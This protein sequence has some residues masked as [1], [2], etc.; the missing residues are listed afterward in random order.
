[1]IIVPMVQQEWIV[2][3]VISTDIFPFQTLIFRLYFLNMFC[4]TE[5]QI[6]EDHT[7]SCDFVKSVSECES[8]AYELGLSD[9][10]ATVMPSS[11]GWKTSSPPFCHIHDNMLYF[12]P[13]N[14][15]P[16]DV[17]KKCI[18]KQN[19]FCTKLP[20]QEGQGDCDND[21]ECEGTLVCGDMNCMN[22]TIADCC[23]QPC[24]KD[25]DC[26]S[27]ECDLEHNKCRLNFESIDWSKCSRD[28]PCGNGEGDCDNHV[29]CKG[30]LNCGNDN[31]ASGPIGI[32]C[33]TDNGN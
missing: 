6:I 10:S 8:A 27:G 31:C 11:P 9:L 33:C 12:A 18:C 24:N 1:M 2:A 4:I 30:E 29:D 3:Q 5:Y 21:N 16:C 23:T 14:T 26:M 19:D 28:S 13:A 32:D 22:I 20:C 17:G 15:G 25:I 7:I